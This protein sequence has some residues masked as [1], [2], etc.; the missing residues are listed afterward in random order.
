MHLRRWLTAAVGLPVLILLIGWGPEWAFLL[1][2]MAAVAVGVA[3]YRHMAVKAGGGGALWLLGAVA[4]PLAA[5][6]GGA[7]GLVAAFSGVAGAGFTA[8]MLKYRGNGSIL[9]S[10][11][12]DVLGLT[13]V[14]VLLS[15]F[16]LL[17]GLPAGKEWVFF[18]L[19]AAFMDDTGAFYTGRWLGAH[20]LRP[21]VSP[22]KTVEGAVGGIAAAIA[23]AVL[24]RAF[25]FPE[26]ALGHCLVLAL[27]LAVA[28]QV[29][30][31]FES[32]IKRASGVKD[33]GVLLPG[34]GGLLDRVDSLMF[35]APLAYYY[36]LLLLAPPRLPGA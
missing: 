29:G 23:G 10:L 17:R 2:V 3:E 12:R 19:V 13:Y 14:G 8:Y 30:D 15:H 24:F 32:V 20:K 16:I 22:G 31:L 7:L 36:N 18:I 25:F 34:H 9:D 26:L 33:S 28:G 5:Y 21:R 27:G 35:S 6:L 1:L 4:L 11:A